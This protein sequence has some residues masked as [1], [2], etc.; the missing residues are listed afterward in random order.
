MYE[1]YFGL[2][3][4]PFELTPNPRYLFL[5]PG[6]REA[7][8]TLQYGLRG[9]RGITL[10]VGDA[11]TGKTTLVQKALAS[12][13]GQ[14]RR[15]VYVNNPTLTRRE[16]LELLARS[17]KLGR[18]AAFSKTTLLFELQELLASPVGASMALIVDEAQSLPDELLEEIRLLANL[19][20]PTR[21]LPVVL[22]GQP[23]LADRLNQPSLRQLKQRVALRCVLTPLTR[24]ELAYYIARRIRIAG[25]DISTCFT[26]EAI[27]VIYERS[28][29]IPRV[30]SV[31][32]DNALIAGFA[33]DQK[34]VGQVTTLEV[35]RDL[36]LMP[37]AGNGDGFARPGGPDRVAQDA[38]LVRALPS[39]GAGHALPDAPG[40]VPSPV[41]AGRP[42]L[43]SHFS[44]PAR[45]LF[46]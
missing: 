29:G 16:F 35:C 43:F 46:F 38:A 41:L 9:G 6:H 32:C 20:T 31:I 14:D 13:G 45:F 2:R 7:L 28:G 30:V 3:E 25:G 42:D 8:T 24:R 23:E 17:F 37:V 21:K 4:R 39:T 19:E 33:I 1:P 34:P 44:R 15:Y 5:T 27:S 22:T 40:E 12:V 10:L 11:G 36:D 18:D 26:E